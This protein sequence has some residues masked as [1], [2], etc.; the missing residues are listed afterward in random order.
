MDKNLIT[1]ENTN[2][3]LTLTLDKLT[4][5]YYEQYDLVQNL[6]EAVKEAENDLRISDE[7]VERFYKTYELEAK[8]LEELEYEYNKINEAIEHIA[9]AIQALEEIA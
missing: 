2:Y 4:S 5:K 1:L 6:G 8:H 3:N 9:N 7:V